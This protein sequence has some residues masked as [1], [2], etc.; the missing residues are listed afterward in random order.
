MSSAIEVLKKDLNNYAKLKE[1][2]SKCITGNNEECC[3]VH[4]PEIKEA[5]LALEKQEKQNILLNENNYFVMEKR[6]YFHN[7][8]L[9]FNPLSRI[10]DELPF[11]L[12]FT[13]KSI[14][15]EKFFETQDAKTFQQIA[16][17]ELKKEIDRAYKEL[18]K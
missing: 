14:F 10:N 3:F 16:L 11:I 8:F 1:T 9:E 6:K 5:L 13:C 2:G 15:S 18:L 7:G 12:S 17:L 4:Y